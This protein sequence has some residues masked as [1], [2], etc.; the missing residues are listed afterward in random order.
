MGL[1]VL[2]MSLLPAVANAQTESTSAS[3]INIE[4]VNAKA[5]KKDKKD[6]KDGKK[7]K[8]RR[9]KKVE[10][11]GSCKSGKAEC[12]SDF[13]K[14]CA[15]KGTAGKGDFKG[16]KKPG[17]NLKAKGMR[18]TYNDS[19]NFA[20]L[21]LNDSQ[22]AKIQ[23]LN[24]SRRASAREMK[25]KARAARALGDTTFVINENGFAEVQTKYLKGLHEILTEDQYVQFLENNYVNT[26]HQQKAPKGRSMKNKPRVHK[27]K[28]SVKTPKSDAT[29]SV[30]S[31]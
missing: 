5:S 22:K 25:E 10:G 31:K 30:S 9:G 17:K 11:K 20:S 16:M 15:K 6:R 14:K 8:E 28:G 27:A 24:E 18:K 23:A 7:G 3:G 1:A 29:L 19:V 26:A 13:N 12:K 4:N 21:N 2:A